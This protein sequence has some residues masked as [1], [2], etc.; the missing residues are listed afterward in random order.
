MATRNDS[1]FVETSSEQAQDVLMVDHFTQLTASGDS[2][3]Q[4]ASVEASATTQKYLDAAWA[5][6]QAR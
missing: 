4:T 5:A 3:K 6:L 2:E 1:S